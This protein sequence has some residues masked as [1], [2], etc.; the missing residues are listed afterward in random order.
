MSNKEHKF[1]DKQPVRKPT[2]N[3]CGTID[4]NICHNPNSSP[5]SL[6]DGFEWIEYDISCKNH[7]STIT[8]FLNEYYVQDSDDEFRLYYSSEFLKWYFA[9]PSTHPCKTLG[10]IIKNNG[11]LVGF[12]SSI[13]TNNQLYEKQ[14]VTSEINFLCV[15]PVLRK[16]NMVH[17]LVSE[18]RRRLSNEK[19][20]YAIYTSGTLLPTPF[21]TANY[22]HY[23]INTNALFDTG[24]MECNASMNF[25]LEDKSLIGNFVKLEKNHIEDAFCLLNDYLCKYDCYPVLSKEE[26]A[27]IFFNNDFVTSYVMLDDNY[28]VSDFISFVKIP[29]KVLKRNENYEFIH[30]TYLYYYTCH[31]NTLE[32]MLRNMILIAKNEDIH[33]LNVLDIMENNDILSK[34]NFLKGTGKLHYYMYNY[35]CNEA[36]PSKI[37]KILL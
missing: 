23:P 24:F 4:D 35:K 33:V 3:I 5:Y 8:K 17:V 10:I 19:I 6:P 20:M 31:I 16:R 30:T 28:K 36:M 34:L 26:F 2:D 14:L 15:H 25:D 1:W 18:I 12:I 9:K 7:L 27:H 22:H 11:E 13:I 32:I 37:A 21:T 29:S